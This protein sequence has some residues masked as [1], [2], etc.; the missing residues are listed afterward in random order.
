MRRATGRALPLLAGLALAAGCATA[1]HATPGDRLDPWE[2]WNRKVF[3]FN[4]GL[5]EKV[6]KPTATT[7]KKI[8]PEF[9]RDGVGNFFSNVADGWSAINNV[10]QAK[11]EPALRDTVRFTFNSVFGVFGVIDIASSFGIDHQYEDFGQTLGRWGF[12]AGAYVVWPLLGPSSVRDSVALPLDRA[13]SPTLFVDDFGAQAGLVTLQIINTRAELLGASRVLDEIAL[14]KYTFVRDA[15]LAR[16]RSLVY[17]GEPPE[18]PG[19]SAPPAPAASAP[20]G[21]ASAPARSASAP[22]GSA[23][24]PARSAS[25]PAGSASAP[26]AGASAPADM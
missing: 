2:N 3:A 17:D 5:D 26:E 25:A 23:S 12:G 20:A 22:A 16:R 13:A 9:V 14:D 21:S 10:L 7:Y 6:L 8:L 18:E 11:F 15:Y 4:E 19:E 24:A 1:P